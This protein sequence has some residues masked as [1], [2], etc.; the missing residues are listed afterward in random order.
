[1]DQLA[2]TV[3]GMFILLQL[4]FSYCLRVGLMFIVKTIKNHVGWMQGD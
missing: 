3:D 1:M 4:S 2:F